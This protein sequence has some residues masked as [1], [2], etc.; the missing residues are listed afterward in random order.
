MHWPIHPYFVRTCP[1]GGVV[2]IDRLKRC[3]F[4]PLRQQVRRRRSGESADIGSRH[5]EAAETQVHDLGNSH[6]EVVPRGTV[7]A[8][9]GCSIALATGVARA[10]QHEGTLIGSQREKALVGTAGVLHAVDVVDLRVGRSPLRKSRLVNT[11]LYVVRHGLARNT[12][13]RRLVHIVPE[14]G[15]AHGGEVLVERAPP[16]ACRGLREV[17]KDR[18]PWPYL[19]N[20]GRTIRILHELV[21]SGAAVIGSVASVRQ[22]SD[23]KVGDDHE[24]EVVLRK[25]LHHLTEARVVL[26]VDHKGAVLFLE[27]DVQVERVTRNFVGT[28]TLRDLH[29]LRR[30]IV[31]VARL[32][33][34]ERPERRKRCR[35]SQPGVGAYDLLWLRTIE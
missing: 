15:D 35:A 16:C 11:V 12:K 22:A 5:G 28:E 6:A 23:V 8:R 1:F 32:L 30:R 33:E 7:I 25:L 17:G 9:P 29:Q 21:T 2:T 3:Y 4:D 27:V 19:S 26:V 18:R 24:M 34:A 20:E 10:C 13:D 14:T 31:T